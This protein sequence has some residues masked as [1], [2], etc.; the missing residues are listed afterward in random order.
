MA[1]MIF[2]LFLFSPFYLC[3]DYLNLPLNALAISCVTYIYICTYSE[4][5]KLIFDSFI[6]VMKIDKQT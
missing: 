1:K 4:T 6:K 5:F 2:L 3:K